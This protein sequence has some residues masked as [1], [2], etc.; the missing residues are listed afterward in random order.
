MKDLIQRIR[1]LEESIHSAEQAR[2][3]GE[4]LEALLRDCA[5]ARAKRVK[6]LGEASKED[7]EAEL[8]ALELRRTDPEYLESFKL[9]HNE[10]WDLRVL[11]DVFVDDEV[12]EVEREL[13]A[14][15]NRWPRISELEYCGSGRDESRSD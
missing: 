10:G 1:K 4:T 9:E 3:E 12:R 5:E 7:L 15:A 13:K 6:W 8:I 14:I 2:E 11:S